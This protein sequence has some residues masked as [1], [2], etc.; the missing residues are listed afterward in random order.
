MRERERE[1]FRWR[2]GWR[3]L[4]NSGY[5]W[6]P[7]VGGQQSARAPLCRSYIRHSIVRKG[8]GGSSRAHT[9]TPSSFCR[10]CRNNFKLKKN[11]HTRRKKTQKKHTKKG[12]PP[13]PPDKIRKIQEQ[14]KQGLVRIQ[15]VDTSAARRQTRQLPTDNPL[16]C[17]ERLARARTC[18]L[19]C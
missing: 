12:E 10:A 5:G 19:Y 18:C 3:Q 17:G 14:Q 7:C 4:L 13:P 9:S 16:A 6:P 8:V 11:T 15:R 2:T 1:T